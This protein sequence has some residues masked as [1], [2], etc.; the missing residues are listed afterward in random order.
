MDIF[1]S[2]ILG[3][4]E[5][6]TEFLPISSTAHIIITSNALNIIQ[7]D[8]VKT[9][10]IAIQSGAILA[11][12]V[13]YWRKFT[14][15]EV[16]KRV[17]WAFIPTAILGLIFYK[18]VKA[19]LIGNMTV[20]LYALAIGGVVLIVFEKYQ[21]KRNSQT[22]L[23]SESTDISYKNSFLI[24]IFQAIAIIPGVS[25]SAATIV[26]GMLLGIKRETIVEFSFLLAVPTILAATALDLLKSFHQIVNSSAFI[27]ELSVGFV[28]SFFMAI[29][30]IKFLLNYLKKNS[31]TAFGIYRILLVIAILFLAQ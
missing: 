12:L 19:H 6:L 24:G 23:P 4:V 26:G 31:L 9:F 21:K 15:L 10:E 25:R 1:Q 16:L 18:I 5:G 8:F 20:I 14:N 2:L 3:L 29:I 30:S 13:L 17:I 11:V 22:E 27:G 28:A 7:S